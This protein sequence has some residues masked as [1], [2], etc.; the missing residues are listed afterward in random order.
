[1]KITGTTRKSI[2]QVLMNPILPPERSTD[3]MKLF[4][5][6]IG[7]LADLQFSDEN[8]NQLF[9]SSRATIELENKYND[10]VEVNLRKEAEDALARKFKEVVDLTE[11]LLE[12]YEKK[13]GQ[14][15]LQVEALEH[16]HE[17]GLQL[18]TETEIAVAIEGDFMRWKAEEFESEYKNEVVLR[19][20]SETALDKERKELE[21]IKELLETCVTEQENLNSLVITWQDKYDQES[22]IRKE[23]EDALS[24]KKTELE[25]VKGLVESY[26][27]EAD[28]MR[29]ERDN[30]LKTAQE[31]VDE[32]QPPP[33]FF[34]PITQEVMQDPHMAADGFT[35]ELEA[36]KNWINTGHQTSPMTNLPLP[37]LNFVPNRALR[38]AIEELG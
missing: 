3:A 10:E 11:R 5:S 31:I 6:T 19:R 8:F 25:T 27:Q 23:K 36:I 30:A 32:Q 26:K 38:S 33:S 12:P 22:I 35:Y 1:M 28:A 29:Q 14:L 18:R 24:T 9:L 20:E 2:I 21:G 17:A 34:C 4:L 13:Q 16:K 7:K 15:Q 37:H